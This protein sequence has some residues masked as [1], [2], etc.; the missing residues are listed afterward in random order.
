M[1]YKIW[2]M[3]G[4]SGH[5]CDFEV[6]GGLGTKGPPNGCDPPDSCGESEFVVL[7]LSK[8]VKPEKHQLFFIT[9]WL[10]LL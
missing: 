3:A 10:Y 1:G 7:R 6:E 4:I 8:D 5:V 2:A 9:T